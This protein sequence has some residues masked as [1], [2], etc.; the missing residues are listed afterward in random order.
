[1]KKDEESQSL[2]KCLGRGG[3]GMGLSALTLSSPGSSG[4]RQ[5][6]RGAHPGR[7]AVCRCDEPAPRPGLNLDGT[8]G[9]RISFRM[10]SR[11]L[12]IN[13]IG[14]GSR[15]FEGRGGGKVTGAWGSRRPGEGRVW[16]PADTLLARLG[17]RGS[18]WVGPVPRDHPGRLTVALQDLVLEATRVVDELLQAALAQLPIAREL[19]QHL[20]QLALHRHALIHPGGGGGGVLLL[21]SRVSAAVRP[22][23]GRGRVLLL[24]PQAGG[25]RGR[26][27]GG[28]SPGARGASRS[29]RPPAPWRP[30]PGP[31]A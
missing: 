15:Q 29:P 7:E 28:A 20:L 3:G 19:V 12:L 5:L 26:S 23:P 1:M 16:P 8:R 9:S 31:G 2:A 24:V 21:G 17:P 13:E 4:P 22:G 27:G 14:V 25:A 30:G 18:G 11:S 10:G 6:T